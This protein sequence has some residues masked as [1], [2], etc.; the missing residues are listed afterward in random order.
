VLPLGIMLAMFTVAGGGLHAVR[1]LSNDGKVL[2]RMVLLLILQPI[3]HT[4]D[5]WDRMMMNRD[6]RLTGTRR[7][8][9]SWPVAPEEF[10][11]NSVHGVVTFVYS[12]LTLSLKPR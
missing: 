10:K 8:Q 7:I 12:W 6:Y 2:S 11:T 1:T 9:R 5:R 4:L 3:R